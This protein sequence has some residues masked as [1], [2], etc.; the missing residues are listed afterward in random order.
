MTDF[1]Y[2]IQYNRFHDGSA[3]H[4]NTMANYMKSVLATM[5]PPERDLP[6][7]D[8][9]CGQGFAL[10]ALRRLGFTKI[11][12]VEI[13]KQ[14]ADIARHQGFEVALVTDTDEWLAAHHSR[15]ISVLLF[16]VLEH[17]AATS[18]ITFLRRI[19]ESL[20]PG[21]RIVIQV[22]NASSILA[23]RWLYNDHTHFSSFTENSLNFVL[24]NAGF[25]DIKID[26][27]KGIGSLPKK[28]WRVQ[29]RQA[30]RRYL[31]RWIWLQVFKAELS[32]EAI[33]EISFDINLRAVAFRRD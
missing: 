33:D 15:F 22:P 27:N 25:D 12:G 26:S 31:V 10:E 4:F 11:E 13:S 2:S 6:I 20:R 24:R 28:L 17:V 30:F 18:Q 1:D 23:T 3:E 29:T 7:L 19:K 8:L 9:G 14:Q 21:G 32:W 5:V 16:D